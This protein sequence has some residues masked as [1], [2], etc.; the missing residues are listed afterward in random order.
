MPI[1]FYRA[2]G[3]STGTPNR[4]A[5]YNLTTGVLEASTVT[6][7]ELELLA[8]LSGDILTTTNTKTVSNKTF[9]QNIVF[10]A[11]NTRDIGSSGTRAKDAYLAG[12]LNSV[13]GSFSSDVTVGGNLTVNG[14]TTT[15]NTTNLAVTDKNIVVNNGGNDAASE[16]AGLTVDR[17]GTDG[18]LIYADASAT[19]FRSGPAGSEVDLVGTT[20]TQTLTNKTL[21]VSSNTITTVATGNLAAVELNA[22]LAELQTDIDGR[23]ASDATLTALAAYNTNGLLT[24]TA[25]DT[26]TGRTLTAGSTKITV[27][28]GNGVA[29]N[30]TVDVD[31]T[32]LDHGSIGGLSD[33]DHTQYL[34]LAGRSGGQV[35]YGG[36]ASGDD[37][38]LSSTSNATKG[39]V[40][41]GQSLHELASGKVILG[42]GARAATATTG[43][44]QIKSG[45]SFNDCLVLEG[46][47]GAFNADQKWILY[48]DSSSLIITKQSPSEGNLSITNTERVIIGDGTANY[49]LNLGR[50]SANTDPTTPTS[51]D[52]IF[53]IKNTSATNNNSEGV[54]FQSQGSFESG[55][56]VGVNE[57][58]LTG[59]SGHVRILTRNAGTL[60]ES[61][62]IRADGTLDTVYGTGILKSDTNGLVSSSA[63]D[64][65]TADV[66]GVL[67]STKGGTGVNNAGSLTYGAN[68]IALTT[69]GATALTVPTSGTLAT[70][71]GTE[72]LTNKDI[73]GGTAANTRRI[74]LPSAAK[75]TLDALTRKEGT[76]VYATDTDKAYVDNG[77]S[78]IPVGSGG[79][80]G[81]NLITLDS[82]FG[83]NKTDN[84]DVE[85][86]LGD[87]VA[88]ADTAD[89]APV[90]MTGGSPN[91][92][93]T[94]NTSSPL[95]GT[96]DIRL[97]ITT[98]ATRQ[99]EGASC[100]VNIPPAY[101]GRTLT[102]KAPFATTGTI[103]EDD[104][105]LYMYDVTNS[106]LIKPF[107]G[108]KLL[109]ASGIF[110]ATF[111]VATNTASVRVGIHI[112]RA[113]NTGA[114]TI[115]IDDVQVTPEST[116][117][118]LAGNDTKASLI[119]PS[120][121]TVTS[122]LKERRAGDTLIGSGSFSAVT[123]GTGT[124]KITLTGY[125]LDAAKLANNTTPYVGT[126]HVLQSANTQIN[127]SAQSG[128]LFYD[129]S[130][131]AAIYLATNVAS[132]AYTKVT[133]FSSILGGSDSEDMQIYFEVPIAGWSSNVSMAESS[134]YNISSYLA[135]G[136]RVT[137]SAPTLLGQYRT[138]LR[139]AN[140]IT[141]TETNGAPTA[142]PSAANGMRIYDGNAFTSA[143]TNNE[144]TKYDIFV[145]KNKNVKTV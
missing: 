43:Y 34:L 27:T 61:L 115:S 84:F 94:R 107:T 108:S 110:Q 109:G 81:I 112:A 99:G 48:G 35:A 101:R 39:D 16:G 143:D 124:A 100:V 32:N 31:Q 14:T 33:D 142:S 137:G 118:G 64:L 145:G 133:N 63:V 52:A 21:V 11:N 36:T 66:T 139:D 113:V 55:A 37:L 130:D 54:Y 106:S 92:T 6:I 62:R 102:F 12:Q 70:L 125:T 26:F 80:S 47:A 78:L 53:A 30:P 144:P 97:T 41:L 126:W 8:G 29:G 15:I 140:A 51:A 4:V 75:A 50:G 86:T 17:T 105:V 120:T 25:A 77:T 69:S 93:V 1:R 123:V 7:A 85:T 73:D 138:Y 3:S 72:V 103:V 67:V 20:S 82:S 74:T 28:N 127:A 60:Q 132:S 49:K 10:D 46:P 98:G 122:A 42:P 2:A 18:S 128:H 117:I 65:A 19:K 134:T 89:V 24:Q 38:D 87:W 116:P 58:H 90:D 44:V 95:N 136:T 121:T 13:T 56:V 79:G 114:V 135:N 22:A 91:T 40:L 129:G 119:T 23:Q 76:I 59:S 57:G 111:P 141:F 9:A 96:A 45:G 83:I 5:V 71:A 104:F 131:T 88:Y 68:N